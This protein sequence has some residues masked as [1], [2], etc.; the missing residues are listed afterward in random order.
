[1]I[2]RLSKSFFIDT[3]IV[4]A[5]LALATICGAAD[6]EKREAW[7]PYFRSVAKEYKIATQAAPDQAFPL[8]KDPVLLWSQPVRGGDDG[9]VFLWLKDRSPAV[10]GTVFCWPMADGTRVVVNEFHNLIPEPLTASRLESTAWT[11]EAGPDLTAFQNAPAPANTAVQRRLQLRKLAERFRGE[12][13]DDSAQKS[14]ELRLLPQPLYRFDLSEGRVKSP[15]EGDVL[16]GALFTL[17][18]G[19]DP[20]ILILIEAIRTGNADEWQWSLARFSD[21]PLKAWLDDEEVFSVE[22]AHPN[23]TTAHTY[24]DIDKLKQP[25]A[26]EEV[27]PP[28]KP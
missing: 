11:P 22:R 8:Y 23:R 6:D 10:I 4:A 16:D 25:P 5:L 9:A 15:A 13:V 12:N 3:T 24:F 14:L 27:Q 21:R 20:E 7:Q 19:T 26:I 28:S 1:M 18:A 2:L 17:A